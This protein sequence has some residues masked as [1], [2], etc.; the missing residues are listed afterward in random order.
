[1]D[2]PHRYR[3]LPGLAVEYVDDRPCIAIGPDSWLVLEGTA[4]ALWDLLTEPGTPRQLADRLSDMFAGPPAAIEDDVTAA[5]AEWER[6][7]LVGSDDRV[8]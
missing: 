7:G 4:V 8:R 2:T 1:M 5:L 6:A 3:R